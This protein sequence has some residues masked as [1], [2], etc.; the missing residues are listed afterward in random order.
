MSKKMINL[1]LA[2][3]I[4][5]GMVL[6]P[7]DTF[8]VD[9]VSDTCSYEYNTDDGIVSSWYCR[10]DGVSWQLNILENGSFSATYQSLKEFTGKKIV[11]DWNQS[12]NGGENSFNLIGRNGEFDQTVRLSDNGNYLTTYINDE[13]CVFYKDND[14]IGIPS[15]TDTDAVKESFDGTWE[16]EYRGYNILLSVEDGRLK[17]DVLEHTDDAD[18]QLLTRSESYGLNT[19][20]TGYYYSFSLDDLGVGWT[21]VQCQLFLM[22]DET[23]RFIASDMYTRYFLMFDRS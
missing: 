21:D 16:T 15:G 10:N 12:V 7:A 17:F 6:A 9:A 13:E 8:A 1:M 19:A 2:G 14:E 20:F 22:N 11:G 3:V 18:G 23:V 4:T 5:A